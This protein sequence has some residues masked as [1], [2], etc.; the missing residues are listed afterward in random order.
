MNLEVTLSAA[1]AWIFLPLALPI[2]LWACYTDITE[3]KIKN[4]TVLA[5]LGGFVVLGPIALGF[6]E[7]AWRF[8][9]FGVVLL[10][11]FI[12]SAVMGIGAG[13]AKF[14]AAMA[15]F[16]ALSDAGTVLVV[17]EMGYQL[18]DAGKARALDALSQ[19]E[20]YGAMP[21]P[22]DRYREQV[23]RQSIRNIQITRDQLTAAMGT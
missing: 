18:T 6:E 14:A 21:V 13:D 8:T 3:F 15:P 11:G 4:V 1:Q 23:K 10:V 22:L 20:Y 2:A 16:I 19:S 7:Y 17:C 9:H 12:L 5:L